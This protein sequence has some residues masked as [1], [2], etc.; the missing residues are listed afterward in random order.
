MDS[1]R[2]RNFTEYLD[3]FRRYKLAILVPAIIV[4]MA[5]GIAIKRLP[6]IYESSTF[7]VVESPKSEG[8]SGDMSL[9][10]SQHLATIKQPVTSRSRRESVI[11]KFGLY[12]KDLEKGQR[13]DD[14]ISD[15]R[16]Q[17]GFDVLPNPENGTKAF[18]LSYLDQDP[19]IARKVTAELAE[20]LI[21]DNIYIQRGDTIIVKGNLFKMVHKYTS[22]VELTGF[23]S[24]LFRG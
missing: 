17:V 19:E 7:I 2:H 15:M 6:N 12:K 4:M 10:L 14:I 8:A 18:T 3:A 24:F 23:V 5:S 22:L 21:K 20:H 1:I 9:E 16:G 13:L 11:N